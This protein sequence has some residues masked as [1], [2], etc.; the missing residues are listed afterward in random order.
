MSSLPGSIRFD[1]SECGI[2]AFDCDNRDKS[3]V[4]LRQRADVGCNRRGSQKRG[5]QDDCRDLDRAD[6][7]RA[8]FIC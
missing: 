2:D 7:I 5:S 3:R 6:E 4:V 1:Y 8:G